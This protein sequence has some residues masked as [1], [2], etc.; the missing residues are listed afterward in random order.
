MERQSRQAQ[1][2][3][4]GTRRATRREDL[5]T[6]FQSSLHIPQHEIPDGMTYAWVRAAWFNQPDNSNASK[7]MRAGWEPVKRDAHPT[8]FGALNIPGVVQTNESYI[9]EGGLVLCQMPTKRYKARRQ[10]LE[11]EARHVMDG[12]AGLEGINAPT[13]NN[14]SKAMIERETRT[15]HAEFQDE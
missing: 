11:R 12:V 15:E 13:F 10:E 6:E 1:S 9:V 5:Q 7:K 3:G 2:R 8:L 4:M 14:S